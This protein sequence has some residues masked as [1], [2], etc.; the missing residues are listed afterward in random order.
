M[1]LLHI[2]MLLNFVPC[3]YYRIKLEELVKKKVITQLNDHCLPAA[4]KAVEDY[5]TWF[6]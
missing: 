2:L 5:V 4:L 3:S 6:T 1:L